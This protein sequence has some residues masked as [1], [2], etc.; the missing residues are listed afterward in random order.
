MRIT[1]FLLPLGLAALPLWACSSNFNH[2]ERNAAPEAQGRHLTFKHGEQPWI[3]K[4]C[5]GIDA[6]EPLLDA[7]KD[8]VLDDP[9]CAHPDP[10]SR[11]VDC[12]GQMAGADFVWTWELGEGKARATYTYDDNTTTLVAPDRVL[13]FEPPPDDVPN[14]DALCSTMPADG[15]IPFSKAIRFRG[16]PFTEYGGG[17]GQSFR[18]TGHNKDAYSTSAAIMTLESTPSAEFP[19]Y[20]TG[21]YDLSS[22]TGVAVW[23]RRGPLGMSTMRLGI[24]ERNSAEDLNSGAVKQ[25]AENSTPPYDATGV[26]EGKYCQRWRLCGCSAGTPCSLYT[27]MGSPLGYYCFD[28]AIGIPQADSLGITGVQACGTTR[29]GDKNTS[30]A[31]VDPLFGKLDAMQNATGACNPALQADGHSDLF[32]WDPATAPYPPPAK[33]LRCNNPY[34]RPVTVGTDWQLI[35]VPFSELRQADE[36][37]VSDDMDLKSVKQL[38]FTHGAGWTDFWVA[39][40]GFYRDH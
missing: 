40:I 20:K 7:N 25:T 11:P 34:S 17:F 8:G 12:A 10:G 18:T 13:G 4:Q 1:A 3:K 32:C 39:N 31:E 9:V 35:K 33:R 38:V 15:V 22:W 6:G 21:A 37:K 28:P 30:T 2:D 27:F 36:A 16:G 29:C 26:S 23:V 5:I 24:T 19:G 14:A